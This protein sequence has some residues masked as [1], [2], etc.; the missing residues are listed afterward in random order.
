MPIKCDK[1]ISDAFYRECRLMASLRHPN[2]VLFLGLTT[3]K[4][5]MYMLTELLPR[6]SFHQLYKSIS[7]PD[8]IIN[9]ILDVD[10]HILLCY[11]LSVD[12]CRGMSYLHTLNPPLIHR[13][14]KSP[15]L[16]IDED[17]TAKIADFGLS[18]YLD[19]RTR[20]RAGS[21]LWVAPE[22][23]QNQGFNRASDVYSFAIV[24]WEMIAWDEPYPDITDP[25]VIMSSVAKGYLRPD[26]IDICPPE[27][28]EL[29]KEM[30]DQDPDK[31]P[32]FQTILQRLEFLKFGQ[33]EK[34]KIKHDF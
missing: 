33:E 1:G 17:W 31:R 25:N 4:L 5:N 22:I 10:S 19:D 32:N 6:G 16:L 14:I 23:L 27:F 26:P 34:M 28:F 30:W 15:N 3:D 13:D 11:K 18:R 21:P 20:S 9:L 24:M 7:K 29:M 2:I 8:G 12:G